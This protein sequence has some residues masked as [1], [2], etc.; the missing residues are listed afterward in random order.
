MDV[1]PGR[2]MATINIAGAPSFDQCQ[3]CG[4]RHVGICDAL[5]DDDLAFLARVA[6]RVTVVSG[7]RFIEETEPANYFYNINAGTVRVF[8]SLPDG[9]RHIIGFMS[10]GQFLGLGT[11]G[12]FAFS[13]EAMGEVKLCRFDRKS[14]TEVFAEFPALERRLL[15]IATHELTM[16]HEQMLLLGRKTARE[17]VASFIMGWAEH[18]QLCPAGGE[19]APGTAVVLP[20]SRGDLADYLGL[21]IETVSRC[22][23]VMKKQ[24]LIGLDQL[25][26]VLLLKPRKLA[27]IAAAS[28]G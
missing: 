27:E 23:T 13:A 17:R 15:S 4:A 7:K 24:G 3:D 28:G 10:T 11:S 16:A 8:K 21:T 12:H 6:Q 22:L 9:R 26:V 19:P 14:L 25:H 1:L 18:T 20:M 2:R 5:S